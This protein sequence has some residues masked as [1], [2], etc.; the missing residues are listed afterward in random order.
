MWQ[1]RGKSLLNRDKRTN[2][3]PTDR[4]INRIERTNDQLNKRTNERAAKRTNDRPAERT[5]G[6]V[7]NTPSKRD[8]IARFF[9]YPC[10]TP[11]TAVKMKE[12]K[13][14]PIKELTF[15]ANSQH[16]NRSFHQTH[17]RPV[18]NRL[19]NPETKM[20]KEMATEC[21][22]GESRCLVTSWHPAATLIKKQTNAITFRAVY[23]WASKLIHNRFGFTSLSHA[24]GLKT[25]RHFVIQS[26]LKPKPIVTRVLPRIVCPTRSRLC[27][28]F[29][30][31]QHIA[32]VLCDC[33]DWTKRITSRSHTMIM[34]CR[35]SK[36][37]VEKSSYSKCALK[38]PKPLKWSSIHSH[39]FPKTSQKPASEAGYML[40]GWN[41]T[42]SNT[43]LKINSLVAWKN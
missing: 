27:L 17:W 13:I 19:G 35:P 43:R 33:S 42:D 7:N 2:E 16:K 36:Q 24:I 29:W 8:P 23:T 9:S 4:A 37:G 41:Q 26:E 39:T 15:N 14:T 21:K 18:H 3:N 40:T 20:L 38:S 25:S 28:E 34:L 31:V 22:A 11:W 10:K 6:T 5:N 32:S 1:D 12:K 30:F